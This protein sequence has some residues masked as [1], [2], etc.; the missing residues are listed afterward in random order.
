VCVCVRE[1][2]RWSG[3]GGGGE[4]ERGR[5][6][7]RERDAMTGRL[8]QRAFLPRRPIRVHLPST[9]CRRRRRRFRPRSRRPEERAPTRPRPAS[10]QHL[11]SPPLNGPGIRPS[12]RAPPGDRIGP[13]RTREPSGL[14]FDGR[15]GLIARS[16]VGTGKGRIRSYSSA[17]GDGR[18]ALSNAK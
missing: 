7:E 2:E 11:G 1:R 14:G 4:R 8:P 6:G 13:S 12:Q 10:R 15:A 18:A 16:A 5:E 9:A 17:D 3:E